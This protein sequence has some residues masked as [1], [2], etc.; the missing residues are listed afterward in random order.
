M[1]ASCVVFF[2]E[3]IPTIIPRVDIHPHYVR[4]GTMERW[5]EVLLR[6]GGGKLGDP[7]DDAFFS[8]C[9]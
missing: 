2:F 8:W 3:R 4:D 9:S 6:Q 1:E 5:I 7:W